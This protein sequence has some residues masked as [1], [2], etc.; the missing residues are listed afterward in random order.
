MIYHH[1]LLRITKETQPEA[2]GCGFHVVY[3]KRLERHY[4][5]ECEKN[6]KWNLKAKRS[7]PL[8]D[9]FRDESVKPKPSFRQFLNIC[10]LVTHIF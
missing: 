2:Y 7:N 5:W 8:F 1:S 9:D 4:H 6:R 3:K 10:V